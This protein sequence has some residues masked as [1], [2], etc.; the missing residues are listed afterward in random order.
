M[1]AFQK[2]LSNVGL[3][4]LFIALIATGEGAPL[5]RWSI[6]WI[7]LLSGAVVMMAGIVIVSSPVGRLLTQWVPGIVSAYAVM[8]ILSR[9]NSIGR[10]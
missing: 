6:Q 8:I 10:E 2:L 1:T 3:A 5:T 4:C 7:F 9:L